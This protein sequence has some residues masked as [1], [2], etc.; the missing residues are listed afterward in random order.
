VTL[1]LGLTWALMGPFI[2]ATVLI[3]LSPG[4]AFA[5]IIRHSA[6]HGWKSSMPVLAGA[7]VGIVVWALLAAVG[8]AGLVATSATAFTVMKVLGALVLL[9]LGI[10]AWRSSF[11]ITG[12]IV[13]GATPTPTGW[14]GFGTGLVTN[15]ANPKA[16]VFCLAFFPQFIP[17]GAPIIPVTLVLASV[18]VVVDTV[19]FTFIAMM[20]ARARVFFGRAPVRKVLDRTAGTVF[21]GLAARMAT[22]AR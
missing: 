6:V 22:L 21:I 4:P 11:R 2:V 15:L 5:L 3:S 8:V 19:W 17:A 7:E 9:W 1:G 12:D 18:C 10:Q 16:M 13:P 20:A 14:A